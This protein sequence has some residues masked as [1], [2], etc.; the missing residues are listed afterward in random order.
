MKLHI[1][2]CGVFITFLLPI[3]LWAACSGSSPNLTA[4]TWADVPAC[5]AVAAN[6]DTIT[7]LPGS[8][9]ATSRTNISKY[10]K[11]IATPGTVT[12]T[13]NTCAGACNGTDM[14]TINESP[15][16]SIVFQG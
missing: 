1:F 12:L 3:Q 11:V 9:T 13:D 7:V 15:N 4:P 14:I 5:Q 16:G 10:V 2:V 8:Y 6:G